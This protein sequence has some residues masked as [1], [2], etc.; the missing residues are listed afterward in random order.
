M[1][2]NNEL[3][4]LIAQ[5]DTATADSLKAQMYQ[6]LIGNE[7]SIESIADTIFTGVS[8]VRKL[9]NKQKEV[10]NAAYQQ[11]VKT[12]AGDLEQAFSVWFKWIMI[13]ASGAYQAKEF[14]EQKIADNSE[15]Y[16]MQGFCK[17]SEVDNALLEH[18][19]DTLFILRFKNFPGSSD[20]ESIVVSCKKYA[21][22]NEYEVANFTFEASVLENT[23]ALCTHLKDAD[24]M[25][26]RVR[27]A[28][29]HPMPINMGFTPGTWPPNQ[30]SVYETRNPCLYNNAQGQWLMFDAAEVL[31]SAEKTYV[32]NSRDKVSATAASKSDFLGVKTAITKVKG[33]DK[34]TLRKNAE[35]IVEE[36]SS[37]N[38]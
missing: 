30:D 11:S 27:I 26:K 19:G 21:G 6:A 8:K 12:K 36:Q 10:L 29:D 4:R 15:N 38:P 9:S 24:Y 7:K 16:L 35:K 17:K 31:T 1:Q 22:N 32:K 34:D 2:I 25:S 28:C 23:K 13:C 37:L 33:T 20:G 14:W 3:V 18:T 5:N